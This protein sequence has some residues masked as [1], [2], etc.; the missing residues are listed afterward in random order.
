MNEY[1]D[2]KKYN[3]LYKCLSWKPDYTLYLRKEKEG[4]KTKDDDDDDEKE[5]KEMV[6]LDVH[7]G[8]GAVYRLCSLPQIRPELL[9]TLRQAWTS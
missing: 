7:F 9:C 2:E 3:A 8:F 6:I 5:E 4:K 1:N